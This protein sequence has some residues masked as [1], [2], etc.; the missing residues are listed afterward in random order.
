MNYGVQVQIATEDPAT[1]PLL[2]ILCTDTQSDSIRYHAAD[3]I[4][5]LAFYSQTTSD[6]L[7]R[8]GAGRA[9]L[10]MLKSPNVNVEGADELANLY[11]ILGSHSNTLGWT[12]SIALAVIN[13]II[14]CGTE[15]SAARMLEEGVAHVLVSRL[16]E[17]E[18]RKDKAEMDGDDITRLPAWARHER[19]CTRKEAHPN[20]S[21]GS[22]VGTLPR[23]GLQWLDSRLHA[24]HDGNCRAGHFGRL[25]KH[26]LGVRRTGPSRYRAAVERL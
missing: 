14:S 11:T 25:Q 21:R 19:A 22:P 4:R 18:L 26:A 5:S 24:A 12:W 6:S 10:M 16:L 1:L 7:A 3:L 9:M 13:N 23:G 17:P 8:Q 20:A 15:A 2:I